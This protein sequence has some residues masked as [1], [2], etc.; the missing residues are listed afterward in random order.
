M[1]KWFLKLLPFL[2]FLGV[3]GVL[4]YKIL[5]LGQVFYEGDNFHLNIPTKYFLLQQIS[6]GIFPL[7]NPYLFLGIPYFADLNVGTFFPLNVLYF[8]FSVPRALSLIAGLDIFLIGV[9]QYV[10]L[11]KLRLNK[12]SAMLG[13]SI[14]AFGGMPFLLINNITYLNVVIFIPLLFLFSFLVIQTRKAKWLFLLIILQ[15]LQIVSGHPQPT[16]YTMFFISLYFLCFSKFSIQKRFFIWASYMVLSVLLSSFQ[17]IPFIEYVLQATRQTQSIPYASS[18]NLPLSGLPIFL[19]PLLYGNHIDGNWW[20]PQIILA[21]F[22]G[23]PTL[24]LAVLGFVKTKF[25]LKKF[26]IAGIVISF[27]LALGKST[28]LFYLFYFLIPGWRLFR[29]PN[30]LLIF[31]TF[32]ASILVAYG[33]EYLSKNKISVSFFQKIITVISSLIAISSLV[34]ICI[35]QNVSSWKNIV[36]FFIFNLHIHVL[37]HLLVYSEDKIHTIFLIIFWNIFFVSILIFLTCMCL[38][39]IKQKRFL[40]I[41][42]FVL[43]LISL[44]IPDSKIITS[45]S[46]KIYTDSISVPK[47]LLTDEN[48]MY[49]ILSLP[50]NLHQDKFNLPGNTYF[51]KEAQANLMIYKDDNNIENALY[52]ADG[53]TALVPNSYARYLQNKQ[54]DDITGVDITHITQQQL[55]QT[56]I[57][58]IISREP[59]QN[60]IL[61]N[62]SFVLISRQE[63]RFIYESPQALPRVYLLGKGKIQT[64]HFGT[65]TITITANANQPTKLILTDWYYPGWIAYINNKEASISTYKNTFQQISIPKGASH[66]QFVY[67]PLSLKVGIIVSSV[68]M[69]CLIGLYSILKKKKI[70]L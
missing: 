6:H 9:F 8:L 38:L 17:L 29:A 12:F 7:W 47:T 27:L 68:V 16:Y 30:S 55:N 60:N 15:L 35:T 19:F 2:F 13:G 41:S 64:V 56:S 26:V 52:A 48:G 5:F 25:V 10:F 58:Y 44:I 65:S 21:G 62:V 70:S 14:F 66:I 37:S 57:K 24:F 11:R 1:K 42:L 53:Y 54:S 34:V 59:L 61:N 63:G 28:P 46:E 32:F 31:Y 40:V 4:F 43:T 51:L 39:T 69:I 45:T 18:G 36:T 23:I 33:L 67:D 20:G 49:R 3:V 22:I 50:V